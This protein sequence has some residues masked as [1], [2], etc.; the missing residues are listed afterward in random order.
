MV[1]VCL[2]Q[3]I[4]HPKE[5]E[6]AFFKLH[7]VILSNQ[8]LHS[9]NLVDS[10]LCPLCMV[11]QSTEHIFNECVN[12]DTVKDTMLLCSDRTMIPLNRV[13]VEAL[14]KRILLLHKNKLLHKEVVSK[15]IGNRLE[16]LENIVENKKN[17]KIMND[18]KKLLLNGRQSN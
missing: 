8:K 9:M 12:A 2:N 7:D 18:I 10:D 3:S 1:N 16:D 13:N 4:K 14:G 15:A 6:I 5:G 17:T 11:T